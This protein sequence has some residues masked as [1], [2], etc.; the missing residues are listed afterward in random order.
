MATKRLNAYNDVLKR[1]PKHVELEGKLSELFA[2]QV[3]HSDVMREYLPSDTYKSMME[4]INS[5]TRLDR[6]LADQVA[7]AMK[8]W[9]LS[10]GATH[11]THWFQP[12]T[13]STAE[14]HDA[15]LKPIG[16]G[17]A[18]ERFEIGRAHV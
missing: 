12:L 10:K 9:A 4:A 8:D 2:T 16:P 3:F 6:K 7:T 1:T 13:G 18:I 5:G 17:R 15:F 14:K 11:Y